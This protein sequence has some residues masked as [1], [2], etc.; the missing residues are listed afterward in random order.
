M[1]ADASV[2]KPSIRK[3]QSAIHTM[4]I[5]K[6]ILT[7]GALAVFGLGGVKPAQAGEFKLL[8]NF[9]DRISA[10]LS[11]GGGSEPT[12]NM[13]GVGPVIEPVDP[14]V[15]LNPKRERRLPKPI[16]LPTYPMPAPVPPPTK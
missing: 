9:L 6:L 7:V 1:A 2:S 14:G 15:G 13:I 12:P 10:G 8:Q 3:T 11:S 16:F 5:Q 4:K